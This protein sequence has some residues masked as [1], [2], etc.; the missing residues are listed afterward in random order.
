MKGI[1][2]NK[3]AFKKPQEDVGFLRKIRF[4]NLF[5]LYKEETHQIQNT[6]LS[7]GVLNSRGHWR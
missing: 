5:V 4:D 7:I 2:E 3:S 6:V 1:N